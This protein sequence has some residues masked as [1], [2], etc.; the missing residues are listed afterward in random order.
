MER[1][2]GWPLTVF[3]TPDQEPYDLEEGQSGRNVLPLWGAWG[4]S[5]ILVMRVGWPLNAPGRMG[6]RAREVLEHSDE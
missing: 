2:G 3:L 1:G 4:P 5:T 6:V